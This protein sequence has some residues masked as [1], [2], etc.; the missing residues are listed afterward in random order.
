[1]VGL[2]QSARRKFHGSR[3]DCRVKEPVNDNGA[4]STLS[5][6]LKLCFALLNTNED[7]ECPVCPRASLLQPA[8]F[9]CRFLGGVMKCLCCARARVCTYE[10]TAS[11]CEIQSWTVAR[12]REGHQVRAAHA[13]LPAVTAEYPAVRARAVHGAR[14]DNPPSGIRCLERVVPG[15]VQTPPGWSLT[16]LAMDLIIC[17]GIFAPEISSCCLL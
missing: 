3:F 1:M 5:V 6:N 16:H 13:R 11:V 10:S 14:A 7:K 15:W 2:L 8:S 12:T 9:L 4:C 17:L